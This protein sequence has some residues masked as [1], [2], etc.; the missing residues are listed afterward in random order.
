M[1]GFSY[2]RTHFEKIINRRIANEKIGE[3]L[4]ETQFNFV[5][6]KVTCDAMARCSRDDYP[7][8]SARSEPNYIY[9]VYFVDYEKAFGIKLIVRNGHE[10]YR[11]FILATKIKSSDG[12]VRNKT[13]NVVYN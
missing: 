6:N 12:I 3:Q 10:F 7:P 2:S 1:F 13:K 9:I 8:K 11:K 5:A 4:N